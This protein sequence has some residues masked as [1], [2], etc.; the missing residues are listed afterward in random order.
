MAFLKV[1][2]SPDP[3]LKDQ[4]IPLAGKEVLIG[5]GK[6][7]GLVLEDHAVSRHHARIVEEAEG[8]LLIDNNSANGS[9][10]NGQ[11]V[12]E[13]RLKPG[14]Q[15]RLGKSVFEIQGV[16]DPEGT[17]LLD[18]QGMGMP[19][20]PAAPPAMP[21]SPPPPAP[22]PSPAAAP[23]PPPRPAPVE[24][25]TV[26]EPVPM[27]RPSPP[28]TPIPPPTPV[29]APRPAPPPAPVAARPAPPPAPVAAR[30]A[31]PPAPMASRPAPMPPPPAAAAAP[32][33]YDEAAPVEGE[34]AGFWIRFLASL[35]DSVILNVLLAIVW[36][37][38]FFLTFRAAARGEAPGA[39]AAILPIFSFL[40]TMVLSLGYT[41]W[42][43]ANKGATPGKKML[44]LRIVR[45]DGE[46]PLGWGTAF[47]RLVG[48]MVSGFILYIG[49]LMI[50]FNPEK[51]GLHDKIAKTRVLKVR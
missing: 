2:E 33:Y 3:A 20:K 4:T 46:E 45:E 16:Y 32:A 1:L 24:A 29:P 14:D 28:P 25:P 47:M 40:L 44:G 35:I 51:M 18:V 17:A 26:P 37:P 23:P 39:L 15:I 8:H 21:A 7:N 12:T 50:A 10:V 38:T 43:W 34:P 11:R 6:E 49:F 9:W 19:V 22:A 13:A 42:F 27:R 41:L 5:R 36:A 31:P 48:Y 30:P